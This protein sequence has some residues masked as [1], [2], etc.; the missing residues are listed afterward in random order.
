MDL[1]LLPGEFA[2]CRLDADAPAPA[3]PTGEFVSIV[4][5]STEL[6]I[7]CL[8]DDVPAEIQCE[9]GWRC[10]KIDGSFGF[11][12]VGVIASLTKPLAKA[13]VSVFV[14]S[15]FD[16]DYLLVKASALNHAVISLEKAGYGVRGN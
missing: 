16:T 11:T 15:T 13:K 8:Q 12:E 14:I 4:R 5:T 3:W 9:A 1:L 6:T 2:V 10:L 7:V